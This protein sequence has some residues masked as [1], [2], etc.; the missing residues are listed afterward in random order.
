MFIHAG[1]FSQE[2]YILYICDATNDIG[3]TEILEN[4]GYN[5]IRIVN[6]YSGI[7]Q[8]GE[9]DLA[10][11]A[12]LII[13]ARNCPSGGYGGSEAL[14]SQWNSIE[15]PIICF[16]VWLTRNT[17]WQWFDSENVFCESGYTIRVPSSA[18]NHSIYEGIGTS[19]SF[20]IYNG[21]A[22]DLIFETPPGNANVLAYNSEQ[23]GIFI[24]EWSAG[25]PFYEGTAQIPAAKRVFFAAG[26]SDCG[27]SGNQ[28]MSAYNLN[29][30]GKTL[31]LNIVKYLMPDATLYRF[32]FGN[33]PVIDGKIDQVWYDVDQYEVQLADQINV[34]GGL[35][36]YD[37]VTWRAAWNYTYIYVLLEVEEDDFYPHYE[38][39]STITWEYDRPEIYLD[40]NVGE[41]NDGLGPVST[42]SGHI[43]F[44]PGFFEGDNPYVNGDYTWD[45]YYFKYDYRID[46]SDYICEF[47]LDIS[48]L[49]DKYGDPLNPA[50]EPV[51]GF[52][53]CMIDRDENDQGRRF[54]VWKN[55]G[56]DGMSWD[57]MDKCGEVAFS[58]EE[59]GSKSVPFYKLQDGCA[60]VIDG[61]K[62]PIW[63]FAE[64][65][66]INRRY[67]Y[68]N[69]SLDLAT[70]QATWNDTSIFIIV[71]VEDNDFYPSWISGDYDWMSDKVEIYF[72]V[73]D[74]LKDGGGPANRLGHYQVAPNFHD[75][76]Y[77]TKASTNIYNANG[78]SVYITYAYNVNDPDYVFEYAINI[79]DMVNPDGAPL[80][81]YSIDMMGFDVCVVDRDQG[82]DDRE[83]AIWRNTGALDE[84]WANMDDCGYVKFKDRKLVEF[85]KPE[86]KLKG[87]DILICLDSGRNNYFWY[88]EN[89][90]L[91]GETKQF[92]RITSGLPGNYYVT[93]SNEYGCTVKSNPVTISAKSSTFKSSEPEIEIYP[94][95][96]T[97]NFR[98]EMSG[99]QSGRIIINIRDFA[100]KII[101]TLVI[102]KNTEPVS[103]EINLLNV[104]KG[105][106]MLDILFNNEAYMRRILIN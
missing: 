106:Y 95:P 81:P 79:S 70:W 85:S 19:G 43:Q 68:E 38:A 25:V 65:H 24:A 72:D 54:A 9:L 92:C 29:E 101:R 21:I 90:L 78:A 28:N 8:Q 3:F 12:A 63:E 86:L 55:T 18:S 16:S 31:F 32:P 76:I 1:I 37:L 94:V 59:I 64:V 50:S 41:L 42:N 80:N 58:T 13:M 2:D 22:P 83:R 96:S 17:R 87:E 33:S 97:G 11:N 60:P 45:G 4:A 62:D 104:P 102:D 93:I 57:N 27:P 34:D 49:V 89:Q 61:I 67:Q 47:A 105:I 66:K 30:T 73:N 98:F 53:V 99:N 100:G 46:G 6:D 44:A 56:E 35:P 48:H 23:S 14:A 77:Q 91:L 36:T 75:N 10:N 40:V 20:D 82:G 71:T 84:S 7:L 51:I 69:P 52:D 39:G 15:T 26:E 5:V 74:N 88:Y 103:E